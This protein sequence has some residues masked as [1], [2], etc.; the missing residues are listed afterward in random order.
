MKK[1]I[2]C[3]TIIGLLIAAAVAG[4]P[5]IPIINI[6]E[7]EENWRQAE[8]AIDFSAAT[9]EKIKPLHGINNGPAFEYEEG[10]FHYDASGLFKQAGIPYVRLHDV[11]YPY[12]K[13]LFA[14]IHCIFPDF[15]ADPAEADSYHFE[16]TDQ[17][18][19]RAVET[20]SQIFFRLGESIDH[21]G[22]ARY[23]NPPPDYEKWAQICEGIIRHY[24]EGF[25]EGFYYDITYWEIWNEPDKEQM[26]TGTQEEYYELY[27]TT[28]SY[29]KEKFPELK[30][31]GCALSNVNM[32]YLGDFLSYISSGEAAPLD[33]CSWHIYSADPMDLYR[34]AGSFRERLKEYGYETAEL[35][36]NEWNYNEGWSEE[37]LENGYQVMKSTRG[38]AYMAASMIA[39]QEA[40]I[41]MAMYYDAQ[42]LDLFCGLY[43]ENARGDLEGLPG[44]YA[45]QYFN[46]LYQ[47]GGWVPVSG[48]SKSDLYICAASNQLEQAVLISTYCREEEKNFRLT[49]RFPGIYQSEAAVRV[50]DQ[51]HEDTL[52]WEKLDGQ[53]L[54]LDIKADSVVLI[55]FVD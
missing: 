33:F 1:I 21:S 29:L 27:K 28:A 48:E 50:I 11:E 46:R 14:D 49:L 43:E 54:M 35:V 7:K 9:D 36:I 42:F 18:I 2:L 24:N 34:S 13:D 41:D 6:K 47:L 52:T 12:G 16:E 4:A 23:I 53:S 25:A 26:W 8:Y 22:D 55:R 51:K 3:L 5:Y 44:L 19:S 32:E 15:D 31:G 45:F 40:G 39:M 30:I 17:Y 10:N 38:S 20:G 37:E